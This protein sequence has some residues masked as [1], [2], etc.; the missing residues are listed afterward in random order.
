MGEELLRRPVT[1][2]RVGS[3][4][5]SSFVGRE[6]EVELLRSCLSPGRER[7]RAA[8]VIEGEAGIGKTRLVTEA[9]A[10]ADG[11]P[12]LL[13]GWADELQRERPFGAVTDA[14]SPL[15][16]DTSEPDARLLELTSRSVL[17][18]HSTGP[19]LRGQIVDAFVDSVRKR[20]HVAP[21]VL[22]VEDVQWADAG[23]LAVLRE[24]MELGQMDPLTVLVTLRGAPRSRPLD[25]FLGQVVPR[26]AMHLSLE[27]LPP[28][29]VDT[30]VVHLLGQPQGEALADYVGRAA[31]NP[32]FVIELLDAL[33]EQGSLT[34]TD[35][36]GSGVVDVEH[37]S[38]PPSMR[39]TVL[40]RLSTL[41]AAAL[42]TLRIA[43]LLGTAFSVEDLA[44]AVEE[45]PL[46]V[47]QLLREP[48]R[49]GWIEGGGTRL[50]FRHDL[51]RE[52]LTED[53]PEAVR[54]TLHREIARRLLAVGRDPAEV[55]SHLLLG[56]HAP[57]PQAAAWLRETGH[58]ALSR[59]PTVA[60]E[61]LAG[62]ARLDPDGTERDAVELE[63]GLALLWAGRI[64]EGETTL[65][66]LLERPHDPAV[67]AE[68]GLALARSQLLSGATAQALEVLGDVA[69]RTSDPVARVR[70]AAERSLA[71]IYRG[72]LSEA[73]TAAAEVL[74]DD[75]PQDEA[76]CLARGVRASLLAIAGHF[77]EALAHADEA[78]AIATA[79]SERETSRIPPQLF[80]ASVLIDSDRF[81]EGRRDLEIAR[82]ISEG[83]G[84]AWDQPVQ[85]LISARAHLFSGG[86]D[87]AVAESETA[88]R[89]SEEEGVHVMEAWGHAMIALA[90][91]HH[92]DLDGARDALEA[93]DVATARAGHQVRGVDWLLWARARLEAL[94]GRTEGAREL[95]GLVWDAHRD[96]DMRSERRLLGPDLVDLHLRLGDRAA[97]EV[98]ADAVEEAATSMR[99]RSARAAGLRCRGLVEGD[100]APLLAAAE[101]TR[102]TA[103]RLEHV[104]H[105][106]AAGE[107]LV[108]LEYRDDAERLLEEARATA[109][110]CG[111]IDGG[112]RADSLL[113]ELGVRRGAR[114]ARSRPDTGWEAL[115]PTERV[116]AE[117]AAEGLSNPDIGARLF[118]SRRTVQTHLSHVYAKL[119]IAS[120]VEL[121]VLAAARRD[122]A[123]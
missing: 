10:R 73:A 50:V 43:A 16:P 87:D 72:E 115:T 15:S 39:M 80:R 122:P 97:A 119:A 66:S 83:L 74:D 8:A 110:A 42:E 37:S 12:Q 56:A 17:P 25:R 79:S 57:D 98:V 53:T 58:R 117:L 1:V 102:P 91:L 62:A 107:A 60:V 84:S 52:A 90:R 65:R 111:M 89:L 49:L 78:V 14:V 26:L 76:H 9:L 100:V 33:A 64:G 6:A 11:A 24:L 120:R 22:V 59:E 34:A 36:A 5:A 3:R 70:L 13:R 103:C 21:V 68:A 48:L 54:R 112:R 106:L 51:V 41:P 109:Q 47:L 99:T 75:V 71:H 35:A 101:E 28:A 61:L 81:D 116:V 85:H 104:G 31:G 18:G 88:L 32:L 30:L 45:P 96:L 38:L 20:A 40:R 19:E 94:E 67:D 27:G 114:G 113:R 105:C 7:A 55:A 108:R 46:K 4:A 2:G 93:G 95:L 121:A 44:A 86:L 29:A 92:L 123:G 69:A 82:R 63:L 23:T 118:I 77:E